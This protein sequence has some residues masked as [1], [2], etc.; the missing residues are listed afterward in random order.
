[1]PLEADPGSFGR[2][3][4]PLPAARSPAVAGW[5]SLFDV[6]EV[7]S[8]RAFRPEELAAAT[9]EAAVEVAGGERGLLLGRERTRELALK[10]ALGLP[11]DLDP[12]S[13]AG[14][15]ISRAVEEAIRTDRATL[16]TNVPFGGAAGLPAGVRTAI[17]VPLRG[18]IREAAT[19]RRASEDRRRFPAEALLKDL[20]AIYVDRDAARPFGLEDLAR[21]DAFA[22][23]AARGLLL[24]RLFHQATSDPLT[25]FFS[26]AELDRA[27]QV[28]MTIATQT[29][30]PLAV[31]LVALDRF[32]EIAEARGRRAADEA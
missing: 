8:P 17:V 28:E 25:G 3:P 32:A 6:P 23:Y 1:M 5:A 26:R 30:S 21:L 22:G 31:A 27:L 11:R 7:V 10:A 13:A 20:G 2:D 15:G 4:G 12:T 19:G 18:V 29:R 14:A 9:L 24:G 16:K